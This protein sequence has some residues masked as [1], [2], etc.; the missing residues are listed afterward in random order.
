MPFFLVGFG[1]G[2]DGLRDHRLREHH[3][4]QGDDLVWI[5]QGLTG[6]DFLEAD[7]RGDV[8]G[9]HFLDFLA[10][11]GVHLQEATDALFLCPLTGLYT[12]SPEAS[13]PE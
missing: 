1:L 5:A 7:A 2:F 4:L 9:A 6:G 12:V 11:I 10:L 8:A 3:A 13:T